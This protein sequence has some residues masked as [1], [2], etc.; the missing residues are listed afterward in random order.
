MQI[1]EIFVRKANA[2]NC[3]TTSTSEKYW[4][5]A[6]TTLLQIIICMIGSAILF[7]TVFGRLEKKT[8]GYSTFIFA[9]T[10]FQL[11]TGGGGCCVKSWREHVAA[12]SFA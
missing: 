2:P 5:F 9:S 4:S 10:V 8:V 12:A 1:I 7:G 11:Y 6:R 3:I